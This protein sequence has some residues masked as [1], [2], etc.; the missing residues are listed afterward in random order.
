VKDFAEL[1]DLG[2]DNTTNIGQAILAALPTGVKDTETP[3]FPATL[4]YGIAVGRATLVAYV[5]IG[6]FT[7]VLCLG[8][9][10]MDIF[11]RFERAPKGAG[12]FPTMDFAFS[13]ELVTV[14]GPKNVPVSTKDLQELRELD[15]SKR[16]KKTGNMRV[17]L[18]KPGLEQGASVDI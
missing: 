17:V 2:Y 4:T 10:T 15:E 6:G 1:G 8:T 3:I 16:I 9:L 5:A 18:A 11:S 12:D 14:S 7:L 13:C